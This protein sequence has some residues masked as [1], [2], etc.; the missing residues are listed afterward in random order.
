MSRARDQFQRIFAH[1]PKTPNQTLRTVW[2]AVKNVKVG[3]LW[4]TLDASRKRKTVFLSDFFIFMEFHG[5]GYEEQTLTALD[6]E[7]RLQGIQRLEL[8]LFWH[9]TAEREM[10]EKT[11]F[12]PVSIYYGK[13]LS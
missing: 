7:L 8:N 11:G 10:Y 2:D 12:T 1:G 9:N 5:K 6:E 3:M 13:D 4:Y